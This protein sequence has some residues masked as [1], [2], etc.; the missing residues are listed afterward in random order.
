MVCEECRTAH[1]FWKSHCR[2]FR[3][4][5]R[6]CLRPRPFLV[7]SSIGPIYT[8]PSFARGFPFFSDL[9]CGR[10]R[11]VHHPAQGRGPT[12]LFLCQSR[13]RSS[14]RD[15]LYTIFFISARSVGGSPAP[16]MAFCPPN[17]EP[18]LRTKLKVYPNSILAHLTRAVMFGDSVVLVSR[19][20]EIP[21]ATSNFK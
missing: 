10:L 21:L 20:F 13:R 16:S 9:P 4:L 19:S 15:S 11:K 5:R 7:Y 18:G 14:P 8:V 12:L 3:T 2:P 17:L 1:A 6:S